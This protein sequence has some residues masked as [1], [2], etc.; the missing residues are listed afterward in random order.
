MSSRDVQPLVAVILPLFNARPYFR[1][2]VESVLNQTY[3][4]LDVIV[5]DDGST[6]GSLE[7]I[8]D[9]RDSRLRTVRQ[10]NSG[11]PVAMN[12]ALSM[13]DAEFYAINDAD[14]L[15]HPERIQRQV[16]CLRRNSDVAAVFSGHDIIVS[17]QRHAPQFRPRTREECREE[18]ECLR[19][20][21]HD[22]TALWRLSMVRHFSYEPSLPGVEGY[23]YI[24][25][26]GEQFPMLVLG[27]CL[28]SY[29]VH[30]DS[31]TKRAPVER[32]R[33]VREVLRRACERRGANPEEVLGPAPGPGTYS[34]LRNR[35]LDN[36]LAAHF[37]ESVLDLR[38]HGRVMEAIR[39]GIACGKFHP[40][41]P[42]YLKALAYALLPSGFIAKVR[43]R[44][45][46]KSVSW[47]TTP[48]MAHAG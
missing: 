17:N 47:P 22:P 13:T 3:R 35:D 8:S 20:P 28:Y 24:L 4:E 36:N 33:R 23:D 27:E 2:A 43:S 34:R 6:D 11:K 46:P 19:M 31:I 45:K 14:D 25:R 1:A 16:D 9:I 26:V 48:A 30:P 21:A 10:P 7:V 42:H 44:K 40:T 5:V 29:R 41:D 32:E 37:I 15:S 38:S 12:L 18:I 39:T